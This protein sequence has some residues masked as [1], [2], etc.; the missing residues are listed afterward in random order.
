MAVVHTLPLKKKEHDPNGTLINPSMERGITREK[1]VIRQ[2]EWQ[3]WSSI[4]GCLGR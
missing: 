4:L 2:K 3:L 1:G